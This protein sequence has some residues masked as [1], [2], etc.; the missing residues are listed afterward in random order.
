[1][2]RATGFRPSAV[3][4]AM[5]AALVVAAWSARVDGQP[6]A[7]AAV[8]KAI[9]INGT[10][11]HF[12]ERGSGTPIVFVH[13]G[14]GDL[15]TFQPQFEAL[16]A[17]F[18][19]VAFSRRFHPPNDVP[20]GTPAYALQVHVEDLAALIKVL[21]LGSAHFIGHSY[22]AL[23][24]L[25][26]AVQQPQLIRSLVLGEPP[27]LSLLESSSVGRG[28]REA[29]VRNALVPAREAFRIGDLENGLRRFIDGVMGDGIFDRMPAETRKRVMTFGPE[30]RLEM[31]TDP[32][33]YGRPLECEALGKLKRPTLLVSG[34]RS[35]PLFHVVT[36]ELERC[37]DGETHA[38]L[39]GADHNLHSRNPDFYI[40]AVEAFLRR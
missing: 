11:L 32:S 9:S 15:R 14:L 22:G 24:A 34:E 13:G 19:V 27:V 26:L 6:S 25:T 33:A 18:R 10:T 36:R 8:P 29:F 2:S 1:M 23:V 12:V 40:K 16:S 20:A 3:V 37:L 31:L 5:I 38:M 21:N 35:V 39:P 30:M 17:N 28:L 7:A 4:P